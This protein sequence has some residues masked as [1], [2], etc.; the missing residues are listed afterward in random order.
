MKT[1]LKF[2]AIGFAVVL[3]SFLAMGLLH[4]ELKYESM[5]EINATPEK[6]YA[7]FCDTSLMYKW[8]P[9]FVS[10]TNSNNQGR[11]VGS[12][13]V[14]TFHENNKTFEVTETITALDENKRYSF[15]LNNE[16]F[17]GTNDLYFTGDSLKTTL[18]AASTMRGNTFLLR[19]MFAFS[20]PYFKQSQDE[21]YSKLKSVVE[22]QP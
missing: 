2:I 9:G 22:A 1:A 14:L 19:C 6:T 20:K 18:R 4:P 11:G 21:T 7:V 5:V 8:L 12:V 3:L 17:S 16:M 10:F 13:W 15:V